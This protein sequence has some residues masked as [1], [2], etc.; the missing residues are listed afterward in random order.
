MN[1]INPIIILKSEKKKGL[2]NDVY[3]VYLSITTKIIKMG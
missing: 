2:G 3:H 1:P